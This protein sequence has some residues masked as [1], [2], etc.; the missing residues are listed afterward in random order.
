[1]R[2]APICYCD[3]R[4]ACDTGLLMSPPAPPPR[5]VCQS[6]TIRREAE[7]FMAS[8]AFAFGD[9]SLP[10]ERFAAEIL[11]PK[12]QGFFATLRFPC[13]QESY[14][15]GRYAAKRALQ[16]LLG[17]AD[18]REIE[19]GRGVIEQPIVGVPGQSPSPGVTTVTPGRWRWRWRFRPVTQWELI[20]RRW[21]RPDSTRSFP[22]F[23]RKKRRWWTGS[24]RREGV[25]ARRL[26]SGQPKKRCP[27]SSCLG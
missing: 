18:L 22:S 11:G 24:G 20:W 7:E 3:V 8:L 14:L 19:V 15:L 17:T 5:A 2:G 27:R 25:W 10:Q 26:R 21:T 1:M 4:G 6:I 9:E 16:R 12:E 23:P 13:R